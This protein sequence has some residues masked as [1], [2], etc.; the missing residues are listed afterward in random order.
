MTHFETVNLGLLEYSAALERQHLEHS[1]VAAGGDPVLLLVEHPAV[2]TLGRKARAGEHIL[3]PRV[4]LASQGI[5]VF[6]VERGGDV[7]YHGPGQLVG[8]PIFA[9][10][11][12]VRDF[13]RKLEAALVRVLAEYGLEGAGNDGYAGVY[14]GEQKIASI[15]VAIKKNVALHGFALNVNTNLEHFNWIDPCGLPDVQMT[16]LERLLGHTVDLLE[17]AN[18]VEKHFRLEFAGYDGRVTAEVFS[19]EIGTQT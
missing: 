2:L 8:Y 18:R 1:R 6:E 3:A 4:L 15:G 17:V 14:V 16:S 10:G 7:T 11:R 5:A 9:V 19:T 13:L 12:K